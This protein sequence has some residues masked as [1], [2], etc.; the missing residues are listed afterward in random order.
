MCDP[1]AGSG[2]RGHPGDY[3]CVTPGAGSGNGGHP[4]DWMCDPSAGSGDRGHPGDC[5]R[6]TPGLGSG[7]C[8]DRTLST[9]VWIL[10]PETPCELFTSVCLVPSEISNI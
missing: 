4:G 1:S 10:Y 8:V 5:G 2:D 6:V 9:W 3:G 7:Y